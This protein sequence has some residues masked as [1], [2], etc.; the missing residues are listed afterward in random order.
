MCSN[1]YVIEMCTDYSRVKYDFKF[2]SAAVCVTFL[3]E[4]LAFYN[5]VFSQ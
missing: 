4:N 3:P 1:I 5:M 2:A